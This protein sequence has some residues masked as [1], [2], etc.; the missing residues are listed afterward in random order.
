M[1][2]IGDYFPI[3]VAIE[4]KKTAID[5]S[6]NCQDCKSWMHVETKDVFACASRSMP[7]INHRKAD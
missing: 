6:S 7:L 5:L 3:V 1:P 4:E 2:R